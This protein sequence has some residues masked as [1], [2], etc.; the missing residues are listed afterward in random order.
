VV[1]T[2]WYSVERVV[3]EDSPS[4]PHR[5]SPTLPVRSA[6]RADL[7]FESKV[8]VGLLPLGA[9]VPA[10]RRTPEPHQKPP[11]S[12]V[13]GNLAR[14]ALTA[15]PR[16]TGPSR[17]SSVVNACPFLKRVK[18]LGHGSHEQEDRNADH[19]HR[20]PEAHARH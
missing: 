3:G 9:R 4:R 7:F 13:P 6:H 8:S 20:K 11:V 19:S 14:L 1:T 17:L 18:E 15:R 2:L 16:S 10:R 5:T 12:V